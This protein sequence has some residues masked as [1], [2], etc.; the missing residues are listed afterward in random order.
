[1]F[2]SKGMLFIYTETPVH[3]GTGAGLGTVDLPIQRE[4]HTD[5]PIVQAG[6]LKGVLRA[7][8]ETKE[9][10]NSPKVLTAFGPETTQASDYAGAFSPGDAKILLFP[11][12]S[13]IGVFAWVTSHHI[14]SRFRRD[15]KAAGLDLKVDGQEWQPVKPSGN[16]AL[17]PTEPEVVADGKVVLEEFS[18]EVDEE[19]EVKTIARWLAQ[20]AFPNEPEYDYW[21]QKVLTSLVVLPE[22]AF[23]DFVRHA[24]EV[25]TRI[26]LDRETKT[27]AG[28]AL[29][30]EEHLPT[31]ALLYA[32]VFAT[33]PRR[34]NPPE[35]VKTAEEI[36][37]FVREAV[38]A[39]IQMGG[40]ETVGRGIVRLVWAPKEGGE[41]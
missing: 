33:D 11:V 31:D 3:P 36:L 7:A 15:A 28:G 10:R 27:V 29:W 21:R 32:P 38:P 4:R 34:P 5:Y 24:T 6:S 35:G 39:R 17:V 13:L 23:R 8:A 22:D 30:T 16:E 9:G 19:D 2:K 12:R 41:R 40:D 18:F 14:L 20:S 26:R 37:A 25:M 1:M